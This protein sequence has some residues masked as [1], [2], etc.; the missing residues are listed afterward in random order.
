VVVVVVVLVLV[1]VLLL[2]LLLIISSVVA[3]LVLLVCCID[4]CY[5]FFFMFV[6]NVP[7]GTFRT[8]MSDTFNG[9]GEDLVPRNPYIINRHTVGV[10]DLEGCCAVYHYKKKFS[11]RIL[12]PALFFRHNL[13]HK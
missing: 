11:L 3:L 2:L 6:D 1:V 12:K 13:L 5:L 8:S 7:V 9:G 10:S 4:V